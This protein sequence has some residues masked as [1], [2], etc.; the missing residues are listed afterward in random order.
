MTKSKLKEIKMKTN[1]IG[2]KLFYFFII[3]TILWG[4][5]LTVKLLFIPLLIALF[6]AMLF[7]PIVIFFE[8]KGFSQ[9]SIIISIYLTFFTVIAI[10]FIVVMPI[11]LE[12]TMDFSHKVPEYINILKVKVISI[13]MALDQKFT[14]IDLS[15]LSQDL[16]SSLVEKSSNIGGMLSNYLSSIANILTYALLVPFFAFFIL[17]DMHLINKTILNYIP[18]R[19]FEIIVLLFYK[20]GSSVQLY[21]RGQLIDASFVG[22]ATAIGLS[23]ISFPFA[24]LVG[25]IAGIGNLVPYFGPILGAIPAILIMIVTPEWANTS[26]IGMVV[27]VFLVV[28]AIESTIVYPIA[29]GNSVNIHPL[30]II[31]AILVGGE[32]AGIVGMII[33]IPLVAIIKTTFELLHRYMS[34][35]KIIGH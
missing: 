1:F 11:I 26:A 3:V 19:Y 30:I 31:L 22:V 28:Q 12:Q 9:L 24:L 14:F 10:G 34:A 25:L 16:S 33:I 27:T 7:R 35:Y 21:I 18:N 5:I 4:V 13:Q 29:V 6:M 8:S 20:I 17:K 32:I 15:T 23:I 2:L